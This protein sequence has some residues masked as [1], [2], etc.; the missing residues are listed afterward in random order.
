MQTQNLLFIYIMLVLLSRYYNFQDKLRDIVYNR[1]NFYLLN[2]KV[3]DFKLRFV[4]FD[5]Q[6]ART[7]TQTC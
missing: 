1:Q 5:L 4:R 7:Q 2:V 6:K 3:A